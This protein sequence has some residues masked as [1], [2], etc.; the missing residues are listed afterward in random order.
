MS[1][2]PEAKASLHIGQALA[3]WAPNVRKPIAQL[4]IQIW[5]ASFRDVA[6]ALMR[7]RPFAKWRLA[8]RS[9]YFY[10]AGAGR[11]GRASRR[12]PRR[13]PIHTARWETSNGPAGDGRR[14]GRDSPDRSLPGPGRAPWQPE[15]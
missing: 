2:P 15:S 6:S 11:G 13:S 8:V 14:G 5:F 1:P 4:P 7:T 10:A 3:T 12:S 9:L